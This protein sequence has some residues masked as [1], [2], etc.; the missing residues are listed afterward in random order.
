MAF[1]QARSIPVNDSLLYLQSQRVHRSYAIFSGAIKPDEVIK[2]RR[3]DQTFWGHIS[4]LNRERI[5]NRVLQYLNLKGLGLVC[6]LG[7]QR[8][9]HALITALVERW[10]PET[11]TFHFRFW[12]ATITLQDVQIMR[13]LPID[14]E[15][16]SGTWY[17]FTD[18]QWVGLVSQHLGI[19]PQNIGERGIEKGKI[20]IS[21][22][23]EELDMDLVDNIV[24]HQQRA[25]VYM[26]AMMGGLLFS[27]S[28]S[29]DV[30]LSYIYHLL[31]FSPAAQRLS[32][33]SAVLAHVYRNLC[34]TAQDPNA[35]GINGAMLL[36]QH[37]A[38][39]RISTLAPQLVSDIH[40]KLVH[41]EGVGIRKP[42]GARWHGKRTHS[43]SPAH[44]LVTC[45]A[46][47]TALTEEHFEWLPYE[48]FYLDRLPPQCT[49][50]IGLW[51]YRGPII[52]WATIEMHL[53][54]RVC[55]QYK[56]I[57]Y[58]PDNDE[59]YNAADHE[60][61]HSTSLHSKAGVNLLTNE[62]QATYI[63]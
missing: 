45:R 52:F 29:H 28:S 27:D 58:V 13:G 33:G 14:G 4:H 57:Q 20:R 17:K 8:V 36:V 40:I 43:N 9:D 61:I 37:W 10:R 11:H 38:Y 24:G 1:I 42:Y 21:T 53:P 12:E 41:P 35:K 30:P 5:D 59:L 39:A 2:P 60:R 3:C 50:D 48:A 22:L 46:A 23:I 34:H 18:E 51:A 26:L 15:V 62:P 25:R 63:Q 54:N 47:L 55:K 49:A 32:W 16:V 7:Q 31:D 56:W 44:V 6:K 19:T